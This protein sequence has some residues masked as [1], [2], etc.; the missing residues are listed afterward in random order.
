MTGQGKQVT[1][2]PKTNSHDHSHTNT[3]NL[4]YAFDVCIN[5]LIACE[6]LYIYRMHK[7]DSPHLHT[8]KHNF[9]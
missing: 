1:H 2:W 4:F 5:F 3:N 6:L 7:I 9:A 8:I